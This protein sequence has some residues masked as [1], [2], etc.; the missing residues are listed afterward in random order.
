VTFTVGGDVVGIVTRERPAPLRALRRRQ[1]ALW[2]AAVLLY[3][4]GDAATTA[5]GLTIPGV[6]EAGP[7]AVHLVGAD[8]IGGL[9]AL[10]VALFAG[11]YGVWSVLRTPGRVGI[12]L[13]LAFV[14]A[15]VSAWNLLVIVG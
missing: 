13:A 8:G 11:S 14:G 2:L 9:L 12:P 5:I 7:L 10:K 15:I 4:V 6:A 3:G 1:R